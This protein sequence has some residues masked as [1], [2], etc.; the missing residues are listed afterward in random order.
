MISLLWGKLWGYVVAAGAFLSVLG[1]IYLK[2]RSDA[3]SRA[4]AREMERE[5]KA[6]EERLEMHREATDAERRATGMTDDEA[7]KEADRWAGH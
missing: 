4:R 7:K 3:A 5:A 6:R 1:G 2:G